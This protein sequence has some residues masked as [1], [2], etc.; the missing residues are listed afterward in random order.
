MKGI[1]LLYGFSGTILFFEAN[2]TVSFRSEVLGAH[3]IKHKNNNKIKTLAIT[4]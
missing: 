3:L 1:H 4:K 2:K